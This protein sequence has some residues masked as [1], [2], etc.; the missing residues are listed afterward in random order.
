M[1]D[2]TAD[3]AEETPESESKATEIRLTASDPNSVNMQM[4]FRN[5]SPMQLWAAAR[6]LETWGDSMYAQA[7][8]QERMQAAQ[9]EK[10]KLGVQD[11]KP[12]RRKAN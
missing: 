1:T 2:Q 3:V 10:E 6:L 9:Q 4:T 7:Q 11:H 8:M 5:V 12:K